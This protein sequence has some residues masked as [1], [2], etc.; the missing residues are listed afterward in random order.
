MRKILRKIIYCGFLCHYYL[1]QAALYVY[2]SI[3]WSSWNPWAIGRLNMAWNKYVSTPMYEE[4]LKVSKCLHTDKNF[5]NYAEQS[6][7]TNC[8]TKLFMSLLTRKEKLRV[9]L[10]PFSCGNKYRMPFYRISNWILGVKGQ[11]M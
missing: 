8:E 5:E 7:V 6:F 11:E 9:L 1:R 3:K 2:Y 10:V 4:R